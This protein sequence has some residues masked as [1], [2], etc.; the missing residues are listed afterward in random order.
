MWGYKQEDYLEQSGTIALLFGESCCFVKYFSGLGNNLGCPRDIP[1]HQVRVMHK[2][3]AKDW[4][5]LGRDHSL[6]HLHSKTGWQTTQAEQELPPP[7]GTTT[8]S[9]GKERLWEGSKNSQS[10]M[11]LQAAGKTLGKDGGKAALFVNTCMEFNVPWCCEK[12]WQC[13]AANYV[14]SEMWA[15]ENWKQSC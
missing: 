5:A 14:C 8:N 7:C 15:D 11:G 10:Q 9:W 4:L 13:F 12:L 2:H 1:G 6:F 3:M